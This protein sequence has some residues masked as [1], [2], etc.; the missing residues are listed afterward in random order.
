M[1]KRGGQRRTKDELP[2]KVSESGEKREGRGREGERE[3]GKQQQKLIKSITNRKMGIG[4]RNERK[5]EQVVRDDRRTPR[6]T[7]VSEL[8][9]N[10]DLKE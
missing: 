6:S 7:S 2:K 9:V 3:E 5:I 10:N 1:K 4:K 8:R